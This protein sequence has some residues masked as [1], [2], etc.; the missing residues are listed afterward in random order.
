MLFMM[1]LKGRLRALVAG[2]NYA[3][4][5]RMIFEPLI[6]VELSTGSKETIRGPKYP[7]VIALSEIVN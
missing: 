6:T 3:G 4:I 5:V 2:L 7:A 1:Q